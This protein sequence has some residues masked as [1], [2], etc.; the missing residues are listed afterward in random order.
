MGEFQGDKWYYLINTLFLVKTGMAKAS[1][2]ILINIDKAKCKGCGFCVE[3]CP[4]K[5]LEMSQETN[6]RGYTPAAVSEQDRCN[7][8]GFC[9]RICPE[10]AVKIESSNEEK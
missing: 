3:F 8:C 9:E 5:V 6:S 10:Y 7:N 4:F 1:K 2:S